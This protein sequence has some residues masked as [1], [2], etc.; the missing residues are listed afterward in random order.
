MLTQSPQSGELKELYDAESARL[1]QE[2]STSK[3]G[4][5]FLRQRSALVETI[6]V[7]L[8]QPLLIFGGTP[9][10]GVVVVAVGDFGGNRF[11]L[12]RKLSCSFFLRR[13]TRAKNARKPSI[14]SHETWWTLD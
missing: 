2:F 1:Q 9:L 13:M 5:S 3:D 4:L 6:V 7:R 10:P 12:I 11:S 8:L 14:V